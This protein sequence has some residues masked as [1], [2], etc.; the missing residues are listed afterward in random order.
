MKRWETLYKISK[1]TVLSLEKIIEILLQ[2]RGITSVKEITAFL[3]PDLSLVTLK[4]VGIDE[5]EV[6]K[7]V[8]RIEK[9]IKK[10]KTVI[11][12]GDYDVDGVCGAAI[13]W[14]GL[15]SRYK[16]AIPYIPH[17]IEEGYGLSIKGIDNVLQHHPDTDLIITVDNGIVAFEAVEY[18]NS[19]GI[20]IIITDHH[21]RDDQLPKAHAIIHSTQLCGA[22][23]AYLFIHQ[24]LQKELGTKYLD[25]VALATVADLV[26]LKGANRTLLYFGLDELRMT[27]RPGLLALFQEA[28][29]DQAQIGTYQ[30]GHVIAPRLNAT[31]RLSSALD[32]LR[33]ICTKDEAR[34]R[35]LAQV[36]GWSN[37]ER[38]TLTADLSS[39]AVELS[40]KDSI[41][42][43]V[44]V[45]AHESYNPGV[46][47]LI[48]SRLVEQY[49]RPSLVISIGETVSKGSARSIKGVNI[50]EMIR[51]VSDHLVQAGGHPMAAGFTIESAKI[52]IFRAS[53]ET[54]AKSTVTDD[55]LQ[56]VVTID[57]ELPWE[58]ISVELY[59]AVQ[60]LAP[61][62]IGNPEPVFTTQS[63][64]IAE[65]RS[66]GK[67]NS[68]YKIMF[69]KDGKKIEGV[70]FN[71]VKSHTLAINDTVDI[72]YTIDFDTWNGKNK[73]CVKIRDI[74]MS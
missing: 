11:I 28:A 24:F 54:L 63:V 52:N 71:F 45:V 2:N 69:E 34:A 33:L 65:V 37:K 66:I 4:S 36:L 15:Y 8:T 25:L 26:P 17:R 49:Y 60:T 64:S 40:Q 39:H 19:K 48:A 18:A 73:V 7:A 23:V 6:K 67:D 44:L 61:Y 3:H 53:L 68:H 13:M 29:I 30:I 5:K 72:A 50:I 12:Y 42:K 46:I 56:R 22:S 35:S 32:S 43:R 70:A 62:G 51:S 41:D 27:R 74:K 10:S 47:G 21:V 1:K 20:D 31:G 38:Q 14:E 57:M 55:H 9:T 58:L 59:K 16:K